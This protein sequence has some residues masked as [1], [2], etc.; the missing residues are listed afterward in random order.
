M[1]IYLLMGFTFLRTNSNE[2]V[3]TRSWN[4]D[5]LKSE[6]I[7]ENLSQYI[8]F[9][10]P[11]H[12]EFVRKREIY[13]NWNNLRNSNL[14]LSR[15]GFNSF[16]YYLFETLT[17]AFPIHHWTVGWSVSDEL[18]GV[19]KEVVVAYS[20]VLSGLCIEEAGKTTKNFRQDEKRLCRTQPCNSR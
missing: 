10:E 12:M 5:F 4:P 15:N 17:E 20:E 6:E 2:G 13:F 9:Q 16:I 7:L 1:T 18:E 14:Q 19:R 11:W 3:W 8:T